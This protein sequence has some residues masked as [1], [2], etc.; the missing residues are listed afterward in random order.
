[1]IVPAPWNVPNGKAELYSLP[2]DPHEKND[3][4]GREPQTVERLSQ[5]LDGWWKP[6]RRD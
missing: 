2:D 5:A 3:L 4:A 6:D 1:M